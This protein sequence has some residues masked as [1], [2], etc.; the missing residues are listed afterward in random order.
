MSLIETLVESAD[1][2][3]EARMRY[4]HFSKAG[5]EGRGVHTRVAPFENK[6]DVTRRSA[7]GQK[8]RREK[9]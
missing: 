2:A 9:G 6:S 8:R 4:F 5:G 3:E 1:L 7:E